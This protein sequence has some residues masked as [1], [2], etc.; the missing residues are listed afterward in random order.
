MA[1][2]AAGDGRPGAGSC[3]IVAWRLLAGF[4]VGSRAWSWP[5]RD[6]GPGGAVP[7]PALSGLAH[8]EPLGLTAAVGAVPAGRAAAGRRVRHQQ[9]L[10]ALA[11]LQCLH[12]GHLGRLAPD[13]VLPGR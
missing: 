2:L 13:A 7:A 3:L 1:A 9:D 8:D 10:G 11:L 6:A 4:V 12:A 5:G